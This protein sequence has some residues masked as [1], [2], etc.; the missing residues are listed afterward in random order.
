[1]SRIYKSKYMD[2]HNDVGKSP[3]Q[4]KGKKDKEKVREEVDALVSSNAVEGTGKDGKVSGG[5]TRSRSI[6]GRSRK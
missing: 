6:W 1:M 2:D 5:R 4:K 3:Q